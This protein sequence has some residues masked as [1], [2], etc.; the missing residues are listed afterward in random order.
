MN[1]LAGVSVLLNYDCCE[2]SIYKYIEATIYLIALLF[3][4]R[5]DPG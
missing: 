5:E 3:S 2:V 4:F 1:V